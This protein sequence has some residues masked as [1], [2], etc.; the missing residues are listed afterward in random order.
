MAPVHAPDTAAMTHTQARCH[1]VAVRRV[2]GRV[3]ATDS[4]VTP[5]GSLDRHELPSVRVVGHEYHLPR[6]E[7]QAPLE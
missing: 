1:R 3:K 2:G 5:L 6:G 4:I 7:A